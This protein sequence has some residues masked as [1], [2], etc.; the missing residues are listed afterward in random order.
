M[1]ARD[2]HMTKNPIGSIAG[3]L[4]RIG[5]MCVAMVC[6]TTTS[7]GA[8]G[9]KILN[10][11]TVVDHSGRE[12]EVT[13]PRTRII[14]LYGAHTENLFALGLNQQII[15]VSRNEVF[16]EAA[17]RKPVFSYREDPEKF[18]SARP[19]LVLTRPMI[20]RGYPKLIER[21]NR[22]GITVVSLQPGTI[23]EMYIYWR[24]LGLLTGKFDEADA[25]IRVFKKKIA[26]VDELTRDI[27]NR[28]RVYFESIHSK[29]K[30]FSPE[31]MPMFVLG[32][33]G[34][35]NIAVDARSVR[36]T[37]IAAYGKE[38][39][40]SHAGE[41]DVFLAQKGVMNPV[42]ISTIKNEPG[43][44]IIKAVQN[45]EVYLVDEMI[46]SRPTMRLLEGIVAIG[47]CLYPEV[48]TSQVREAFQKLYR[49]GLTAK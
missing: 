49:I 48:F 19:D 25:M 3:R 27:K 21:L 29:M 33:A 44:H 28:K 38:R 20:D 40:L 26:R 2:R 34:G 30:T 37:N 23:E 16:P 5:T 7:A 41:I 11:K 6:C 12:I 1:M 42:Q 10:S 39:I 47:I 24:V 13:K 14:S 8:D 32:K 9:I 36:G 46:V 4:I 22:S 43:F 18:L 35:I 31:A 17:R 15:G 45:R